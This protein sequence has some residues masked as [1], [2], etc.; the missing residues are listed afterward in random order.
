MNGMHT[1]Y[2]RRFKPLPELSVG[3]RVLYRGRGNWVFGEI[4]GRH[5]FI[6]K[7]KLDSGNVCSA[8]RQDL[9]K[10]K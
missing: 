7:V 10:A 2:A 9:R 3:D 8:H 6:F 5:G 1:E 4:V